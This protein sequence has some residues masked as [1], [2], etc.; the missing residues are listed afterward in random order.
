[1]KMEKRAVGLVLAAAVLWMAGCEERQMQSSSQQEQAPPA[2]QA[3]AAPTTSQPVQQEPVSQPEEQPASSQAPRQLEADFALLGGMDNQPV[4]WGPGTRMNADGRPEAPVLLDEQYAP[5][6]CDFIG[7]DEKKIYLTFDQG[8]ENGYTAKIL[9]VLKEKQAPAVFFLTGHYANTAPELIQ[10]MVDEGH[11]LGNHSENHKN[12]TQVDLQTAF[13]EVQQ[14][15]DRILADY[16]YEMRLFRFPEGVFSEQSA[17]LLQQM[18]YQSVF[19]SFAY[20]D[21]DPNNQMGAEAAFAKVTGGLHNGEILLLH[22]VGQDN[23]EILGDFI[24]YAREQG[25]EIARYEVEG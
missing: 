15:H 22:S 3:Q 14:L 5:Y 13:E 8:Y 12:F 11:V 7:A 24:D 25:Y 1:M 20:Q 9:D 2:S 16:G 21:W 10:R 19:W 4:T 6:G 18:G 23:C 17:A